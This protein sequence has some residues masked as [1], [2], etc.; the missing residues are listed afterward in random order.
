[1]TGRQSGAIPALNMDASPRLHPSP[2]PPGNGLAATQPATSPLLALSNAPARQQVR[3][4]ESCHPP[5]RAV[6]TPRSFKAAAIARSVVAPSAW[7]VTL[8]RG[9]PFG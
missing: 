8:R 1:M 7:I 6:R 5:P 9:P 3:T 4:V 2:V